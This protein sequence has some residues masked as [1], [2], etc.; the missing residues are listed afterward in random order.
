MRTV[1]D[2]VVADRDGLAHSADGAVF[3]ENGHAAAELGQPPRGR[4]TRGPGAE[5]TTCG[6]GNAAQARLGDDE[7][8][9]IHGKWQR[10]K[11]QMERLANPEPSRSQRRIRPGVVNVR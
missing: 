4:H 2:G 10:A 8:I 3:L 7:V 1:V 11:R 6:C 9:E 5:T